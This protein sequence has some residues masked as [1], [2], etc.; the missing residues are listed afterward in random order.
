[1]TAG[2][3]NDIKH[4]TSLARAMVVDLGMSD[5]GPVNWNNQDQSFL[6]NGM[7]KWLD[8]NNIS[9]AIQEKIDL[10]SKKLLTVATWKP[11]N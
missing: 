10:E 1:M 7:P 8:G 6:N 4:A 5:M 3:G 2:A 9:P 11:R